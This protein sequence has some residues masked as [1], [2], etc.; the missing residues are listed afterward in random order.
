LLLPGIRLLRQKN[1]DVWVSANGHFRRTYIF[2]PEKHGGPMSTLGKLTQEQLREYLGI[3]LWT[4]G[5]SPEEGAKFFGATGRQVRRWMRGQIPL[6]EK[7][8][9][10]I[11][12]GIEYIHSNLD[13]L[14]KDAGKAAWLGEIQKK[15]FSPDEIKKI[16]AKR[17]RTR[18][19]EEA[20][21]QK[22]GAFIIELLN[23]ATELERQA[24]L[25]SED[26]I[27]F[28]EILW[29]AKQHG[30]RLPRVL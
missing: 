2:M 10:K 8:M 9:E 6:K 13:D 30:V 4:A 17:Y 12:R 1:N 22:V 20:F 5:L 28:Q 27:A 7:Q 19:G 15:L 24:Y 14:Q 16:E 21:N 3:T 26:L 11:K 29:L 18:D 23:A 25:K